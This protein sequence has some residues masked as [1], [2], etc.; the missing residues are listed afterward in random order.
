MILYSADLRIGF[1]ETL[2]TVSESDGVLEI[3]VGPAVDDD[4]VNIGIPLG[5]RITSSDGLAVGN[6]VSH[7][8]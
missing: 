5:F 4:P 8:I 7:K 6:E 1:Q 2:Y 3:T